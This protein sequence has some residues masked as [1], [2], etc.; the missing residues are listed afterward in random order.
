MNYRGHLC[1]GLVAF[2]IPF[3]LKMPQY[4]GQLIT[5]P[6]ALFWLALCVF[7]ALFP[8]IDIHSQGRKIWFRLLFCGTIVALYFVRHDLLLPI[9]A[10]SIAPFCLTHRGLTHRWWFLLIAP[11]VLVAAISKTHP[12]LWHT[13]MVAAIFFTCGTFSHLALDYWPRMMRKRRF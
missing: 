5:I 12:S 8:D 10:L 11:S 6:N 7:G 9:I 2:L 1:G 4:F 3:T 13:A